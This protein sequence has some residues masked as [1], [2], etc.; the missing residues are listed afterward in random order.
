M[1]YLYLIRYHQITIWRY[2]FWCPVFPFLFAFFVNRLSS[3]MC[4]LTSGG[5]VTLFMICGITWNIFHRLFMLS[6]WKTLVKSYMY[7]LISRQCFPSN[8]DPFFSGHF[9]EVTMIFSIDLSGRYPPYPYGFASLMSCDISYN[10][11]K[12]GGVV[13]PY[14]L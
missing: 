10:V 3:S 11:Q 13:F 1:V 14:Q 4:T 12:M 2:I 8:L 7:N 5:G 6:F 9:S